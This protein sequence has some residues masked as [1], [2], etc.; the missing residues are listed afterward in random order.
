M[1]ISDWSSDVCS[2]D[3]WAAS[4]WSSWSSPATST[5]AEAALERP[6]R[7]ACCQ[8]EAMVP[9]QP[10]STTASSQQTSIPRS[11]AHVATTAESRQVKRI[12]RASVCT[13]V[14]N[15]QL[16]YRLQSYKTH[17]LQL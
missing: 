14:T 2:S 5:A 1:R 3:L 8:K 9:G 13:T 12:G 6:A 7:P 16:H 10:S 4:H 17:L 11:R 15:E